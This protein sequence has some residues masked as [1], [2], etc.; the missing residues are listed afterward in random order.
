MKF[1][2]IVSNLLLNSQKKLIKDFFF[3][4]DRNGIL[5]I[6][7]ILKNQVNEILWCFSKFNLK[8]KKRIY[9]S[10]WGALIFEKKGFD[11]E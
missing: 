4:L 6:S 5:V 9:I 11:S 3:Y 7:G 2:L 10:S 8:L 1:D